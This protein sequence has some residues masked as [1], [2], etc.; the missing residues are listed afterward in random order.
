MRS[1]HKGSQNNSSEPDESYI[2]C[3]FLYAHGTHCDT[4]NMSRALP[5]ETF[6]N[7]SNFAIPPCNQA[8]TPVCLIQLYRMPTARITQAGNYISVVGFLNQ[9]ANRVDLGAFLANFRPDLNGATFVDQAI[10][11]GQ[12]LQIP[13]TAGVEANI[14]IQYTV[15]LVNFD[16][17]VFISSGA[18]DINGWIGLA[19]YWLLQAAPPPVISIS[20]GFN[21]FGVSQSSANTLCNL[22]AQLGTRGVSVI[23]ASGDGGVSG[24][25]LDNTCTAF[26][27]TFPASCPYVTAVGATVGIPE[28]GAGL[29]AG[30][31]SNY[32]NQP[33][34]QTA[35]V[36][37]YLNQIFP[38][39]NGLFNPT[40][41][42]YPDV[43]AQGQNVLIFGNLSV[44]PVDGTSIAA[45]IFASIITLLNDLLISRTRTTLGFLNPVLY[46]SSGILND[47]I[48]GN[49]P[50]CNTNGFPAAPG[51]DPV[52]GLGTPNFPRMAGLQ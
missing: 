2:R 47:I 46:A 1:T 48:A 13:G 5:T 34:Y 8:I 27:P 51:W 21:E 40:G 44:I 32:F 17:V 25:R 15:S 41:R 12:N 14:D 52:T 36:N 18:E 43:S 30:G 31:F 4:Y 33:S 24:S 28:V 3:F 22:F 45:P 37:G 9:Y 50:G 26:V 42:A 19:N 6:T 16:P 39:Y 10:N 23:I 38:A 7:S 49:N 11:G 29:S 35:A 20:Y